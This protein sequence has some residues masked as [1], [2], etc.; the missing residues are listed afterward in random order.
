MESR[1]Q[2]L[3]LLRKDGQLSVQQAKAAE[4][5]PVRGFWAVRDALRCS[6]QSRR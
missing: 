4:W 5:F 6:D 2:S 3:L 1:V